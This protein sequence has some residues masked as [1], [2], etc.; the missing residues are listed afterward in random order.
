MKKPL[1]LVTND[2]G[3][4]SPGLRAAVEAVMELGEITVV[5]P[6][7]Q[8]TSMSRS[9][10]GNGRDPLHKIDYKIKGKNVS[11]YH[12][13]CSP[14][15]LVIHSLQVLFKNRK[16]DLLVSGINYGENLGTNIGLSAT[17]G[18]AF[19]AAV[20]GIPALAVSL[21]TAIENHLTHTELDW[22]A[23]LHFTKYFAG[24]ILN[25]TLPEDVDV[26]NINI[27]MDA[28]PA[29]A[30][31]ITRQSRQ[32][33]FANRIPEPAAESTI[34]EGKCVMGFDK[35]RIETN[36]DIQA[37]MQGL[38]SVTPLSVDMTSRVSLG[39]IFGKKH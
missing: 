39:D 35:R 7:T 23:A 36:S 38:V 26:V 11:A 19:E 14:A 31:T 37:I 1:I 9:L 12:V 10:F 34:G 21:Q 5:A 15:K 6:T 20:N 18:A 25:Q 29:T 13:D 4:Q 22:S 33:Y 8:Q 28:T 30:W 27:P 2:D 24:K 3:I 17:C 16:P 32:P